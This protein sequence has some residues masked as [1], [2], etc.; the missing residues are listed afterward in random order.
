MTIFLRRKK[1]SDV[2]I[3]QLLSIAYLSVGI[4]IA[5]NSDL[6]KKIFRDFVENTTCLYFGGI[7]ALVVGFLLVTF[8]NTWTKDFSVIITI[9]GWMALIKG[10][11]ILV[12]PKVMVA[13]TKAMVEKENFFK[14]ESVIIIILGLGLAFLGFCPK[15]PL[16]F[17]AG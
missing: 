8:H 9:L 5:V 15:S 16:F 7:M 14:I 12:L 17:N 6:Y 1:M 3:F 13:L 11:T 2:Q 4:G 10:V